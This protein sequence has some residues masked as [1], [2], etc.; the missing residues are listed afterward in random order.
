AAG[1]GGSGGWGN[2]DLP[3]QVFIR[4][5]RPDVPGVTSVNGWGGSIGG[6]GIGLCS[7]INLEM[8]SPQACDAEIFEDVSRAAPAGTIILMSIEP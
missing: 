2:L 8:I 4:A 5:F 7:Y 6:F 3:F 1:Y